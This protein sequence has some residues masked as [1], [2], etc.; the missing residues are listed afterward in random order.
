MNKNSI[1]HQLLVKIIVPVV[2]VLVGLAFYNVSE[3]DEYV[4]DHFDVVNKIYSDEIQTFLEFQD[5]S[6]KII[7]QNLDQTIQSYSYQI[8]NKDFAT[9][10]DIETMDLDQLRNKMDLDP[11]E[12]DIYIINKRGD[13]VNT[14]FTTDLG[15]NVFDFGKETKR[16]IERVFKNR[17]YE[18]GEFSPES[19]TNILRKYTYHCTL[20]GKYIVE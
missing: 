4:S 18:G 5:H 9:T 2:I 16:L 8:V 20:D 10:E 6:L 15:K 1:F 7:E 3:S 11:S 12:I 17:S 19:E 14:T 13:I